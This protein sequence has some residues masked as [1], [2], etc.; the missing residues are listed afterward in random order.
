MSDRYTKKDCELAVKMLA[1]RLGRPDTAIKKTA[2][3]YD[4]NVGAIV[5]DYNPTYG[6]AVI[7]EIANGGGGQGNPFGGGRM[8][9]REFCRA[10][11]MMIDAIDWVR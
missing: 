8:K 4:Y 3:G 11:S 9:A 2:D 6:G 1:K 5:L 7:V 10:V